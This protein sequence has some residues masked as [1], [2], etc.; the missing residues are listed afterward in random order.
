MILQNKRES[1]ACFTG[2][3]HIQELTAEQISR[4]IRYT[5]EQLLDRGITDYYAGG[6]LGFDMIAA[7]TVINMK[8]EYPNLKLYLAIPCKNHNAMW[9]ERD[10]ALF[11]RVLKRADGSVYVTEKEYAPGCMQMR[12]RYMVDC[13]SVCVAYFTRSGS[14]TGNTVRYA[15]QKDLEIINLA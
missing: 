8:K 14:G 3:R 12:N 1:S 5:V 10:K 6:A 15:Q 9:N 4:K 2:H 11:E 13:S 7:I